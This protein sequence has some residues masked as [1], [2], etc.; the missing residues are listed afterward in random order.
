MRY[1]YVLTCILFTGFIESAHCYSFIEGD[2]Q[3][4]R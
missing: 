3:N 4:E 1:G 2:L